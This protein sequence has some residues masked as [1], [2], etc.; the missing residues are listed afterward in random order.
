MRKLPI[1]ATVKH[2]LNSVVTYRGAGIRIGLLWIIILLAFNLAGLFLI[3]QPGQPQPG[4]IGLFDIVQIVLGLIAFYSIAVNWHRFVLRD[5]MPNAQGALRLDG[6]VW[7]YTGNALLIALMT[8]LPVAVLAAILSTLIPAAVVLVFPAVAVAGTATFMLS[9][10]LPAIALG[11]TDFRFADAMK[12][13][14]G[15][16]WQVMGVLLLSALIVFV[17]AVLLIVLAALL[18][19]LPRMAA[20]IIGLAASAAVNLFIILFS[21]SVL[22]SL[23]G[24]FVEGRNF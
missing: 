16:F 23:Y 14:E 4:R 21:A 9:L 15:N 2:A 17:A 10:K 6:L 20:A 3:D 1:L 11:R 13:A 5:E 12:A 22:N 8:F 24:Y 7:R 19:Y 18:S